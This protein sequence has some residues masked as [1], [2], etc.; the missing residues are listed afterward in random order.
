M[1]DRTTIQT[2]NKIANW[3]K[4]KHHS[5]KEWAKQYVDFER[6]LK[7]KYIIDVGCA[8][9][10]DTRH[11]VKNGFDVVGVDAS[12]SMIDLAKKY[13]PKSK[14]YRK[15]MLVMRFNKKFDGMWCCATVLHIKKKDVHRLLNNFKNLIK[16]NGVL[17]ISVKKGRGERYQIYPDGTKRFLAYYSEKELR[18]VVNKNGFNTILLYKNKDKKYKNTTWISL[19]ALRKK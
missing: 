11:F 12:K 7:G 6:L 14:F 3:F 8:F 17:F 4:S 18:N 5:E 9:G 15:D 1:A 16:I 13:V 19:F 2:Y 10:R